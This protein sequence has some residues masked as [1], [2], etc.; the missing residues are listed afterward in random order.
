[1]ATLLL[2]PDWDTD[3]MKPV[4]DCNLPLHVLVV[5]AP[6]EWDDENYRD[7]LSDELSEVYG[8]C[9]YGYDIVNLSPDNRQGRTVWDQ[10]PH[11]AIMG[12]PE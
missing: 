11:L 7:S 2:K 3:G 1:M 9:H 4:E 12:S 8:F 10:W 6:E 5:D